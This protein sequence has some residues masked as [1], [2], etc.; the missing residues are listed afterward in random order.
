MR[1]ATCDMCNEGPIVSE[2]DTIG[3]PEGWKILTLNINGM[4]SKQKH[5]CSKCLDK[6]EIAKNP[7]YGKM[8]DKLYDI[9]QEIIC[10]EVETL[11]DQ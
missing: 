4:R 2:Y 10:E 1:Y 8:S 11:Q 9:L 3:L 6:L 7:Q 5:I